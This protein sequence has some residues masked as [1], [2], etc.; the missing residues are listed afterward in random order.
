[1]KN[2]SSKTR[3]VV[4]TAASYQNDFYAKLAKIS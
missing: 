4:I 3:V 1:M 2:R